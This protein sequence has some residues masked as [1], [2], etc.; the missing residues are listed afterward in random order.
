MIKVLLVILV[1]QDHKVFKVQPA[2]IQVAKVAKVIKA[3]KVTLD[4]LV[5][6]VTLEV[7]V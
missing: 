6:K 4:M 5:V 1:T 7:R 3:Y 2:A